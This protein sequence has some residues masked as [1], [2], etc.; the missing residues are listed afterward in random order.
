MF[1]NVFELKRFHGIVN[2]V[3]FS[4]T[5]IICRIIFVNQCAQLLI[6]SCSLFVE[7]SNH[8]RSCMK[9]IINRC[10]GNFNIIWIATFTIDFYQTLIQ[11][12]SKISVPAFLPHK[13]DCRL[14]SLSFGIKFVIM[15]RDFYK[16][17]FLIRIIHYSEYKGI[18]I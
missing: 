15:D 1:I 11:K 16:V 4:H 10:S 2:A 18:I 12:E 9:F 14:I 13:Y 3:Y 6:N 17:W 8:F 5:G 7:I